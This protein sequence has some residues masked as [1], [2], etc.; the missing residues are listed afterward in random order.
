MFFSRNS[1]ILDDLDDLFASEMA[2]IDNMIESQHSKEK[3][4]EE[5]ERR[6]SE[7]LKK[8]EKKAMEVRY[9]SYMESDFNCVQNYMC[10]LLNCQD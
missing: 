7:E 9:N 1:A 2:T 6:E 10:R 8:I 4:A 3:E 5:R